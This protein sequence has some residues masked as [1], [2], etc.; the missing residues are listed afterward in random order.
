M[1][2]LE[3]EDTAVEE[4]SDLA[5]S[6][7]PRTIGHRTHTPAE[8][9]VAVLA[10][11]GIRW[12]RAVM[13]ALTTNRIN[14]DLARLRNSDDFPLR[15]YERLSTFLKDAYAASP[16][17]PVELLEWRTLAGQIRLDISAGWEAVLATATFLHAQGLPSTFHLGSLSP[18]EFYPLSEIS[19]NAALLRSLWAAARATSS[20][21]TQGAFLAPD[22]SVVDKSTLVK[23]LKAHASQ[24]GRSGK[25]VLRTTRKLHLP[26]TFG[27][28]GPAQRIKMLR[29]AALTPSVMDRFVFDATS[30]NLIK[31]AKG[32]LPS[33]ASAFRCYTDFC[34]LRKI[35]ALPVLGETV[36]QWSSLFA[37]TATYGN[38]VTHLGKCCFFLRSPTTWI[39][40]IARHVAK[41]LMKCQDRSCRFP[42]FIRG[43][44]LVKIIHHESLMG[45]FAQAAFLSFFSPSGPHLKPYSWLDPIPRMPWT[46]FPLKLRR[47]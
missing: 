30:D 44:L 2:L 31:Q 43:Q 17:C 14:R 7:L 29:A 8:M 19:P 3:N 15:E 16:T 4:A 35:P 41:G 20:P 33:M 5:W 39:A 18:A 28:L 9:R 27:Q 34:E 45:E 13:C 37:N 6:H 10:V 22:H 40:P 24:V 25:L 32:S 23:A 46:P 21:H 42:N 47:L 36:L 38:Y 12:N 1:V 26:R 11:Y